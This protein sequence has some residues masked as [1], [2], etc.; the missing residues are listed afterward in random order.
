MAPEYK[1]QTNF[2]F[3]FSTAL[4]PRSNADGTPVAA[5]TRPNPVLPGLSASRHRSSSEMA[6]APSIPTTTARG[7]PTESHRASSLAAPTSPARFPCRI[8]GCLCSVLLTL[9][10]N[11]KGVRGCEWDG[12]VQRGFILSLVIW[13]FSN[14]TG[15][16]IYG[17]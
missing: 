3:R 13:R 16:A 7:I 1:G 10:N 17:V 9:A 12:G 14:R 8:L 15:F 11:L 5:P 2:V 6:S 4:I